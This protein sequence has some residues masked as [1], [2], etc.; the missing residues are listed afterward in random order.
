[1][2]IPEEI[3]GFVHALEDAGID[4]LNCSS[5][6][7]WKPAVE[8]SPLNLAGWA[9]KYANVPVVSVGSLGLKTD[10]FGGMTMKEKQFRFAGQKQLQILADQFDRNEFDLMGI[11]RSIIGDASWLIKV[12]DGEYDKIRSFTKADIIGDYEWDGSAP[13]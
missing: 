1:M 10:L 8:G 7:F 9:K 4:L 13:H 2:N 5:R 12:R 6:Y 3:E 11:G